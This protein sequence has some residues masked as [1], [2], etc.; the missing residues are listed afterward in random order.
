MLAEIADDLVAGSLPRPALAGRAG[1]G[2]AGPRSPRPPEWQEASRW[3]EVEIELVA[4][5]RDLL[6]SAGDLLLRAGTVPSTAASK[7]SRLLA[8]APAGSG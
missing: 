7:L 6:D 1:P 8:A 5:P 3:R 4:A 2:A